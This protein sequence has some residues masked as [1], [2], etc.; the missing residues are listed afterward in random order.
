LDWEIH[1]VDS[2]VIHVHQHTAK[3]KERPGQRSPQAQLRWLLD[4]NPHPR[5]G[6]RLARRLHTDAGRAHNES[7]AFEA[8]MARR[9]VKR[10]AGADLNGGHGGW[11]AAK[12]TTTSTLDSI[13]AVTRLVSAVP[14]GNAQQQGPFS[15]E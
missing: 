6:P 11:V 7:T 5:R 10:P 13:C 1:Y 3:A 2:S 9:M 12:P 8:L 15:K 14:K 4:Q